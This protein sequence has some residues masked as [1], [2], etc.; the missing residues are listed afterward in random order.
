[1]AYVAS[2]RT[3]Q[4]KCPT[5][6]PCLLADTDESGFQWFTAS[7]ATTYKHTGFVGLTHHGTGTP[8]KPSH[9]CLIADHG[10]VVP[11]AFSGTFQGTRHSIAEARG[12]HWKWPMVRVRQQ[13]NSA[14]PCHRTTSRVATMT[15]WASVRQ[16]RFFILR[17]TCVRNLLHLV[18]TEYSITLRERVKAG[19]ERLSE[20]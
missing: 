8:D 19:S 3:R 11:D 17:G 18:G 2:P 13:V 20:G 12:R 1:M 6:R 14:S 7:M 15:D 16:T 5:D 10:V 9:Q 4:P